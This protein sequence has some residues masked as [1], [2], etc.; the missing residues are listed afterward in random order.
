MALVDDVDDRTPTVEN[1]CPRCGSPLVIIGL[2]GVPP[3]EVTDE[4]WDTIFAKHCVKAST[5]QWC[6][7]GH[8]AM[9]VP[10]PFHE[11]VSARTTDE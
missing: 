1:P 5:W 10:H 6:R 3:P 4:I 9:V 2:P 7:E 8:L 11:P